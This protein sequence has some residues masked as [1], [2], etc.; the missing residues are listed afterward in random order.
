[1]PPIDFNGLD[2]TV[3]GPVRLGVLTALQTDG[4]LDFTTLKQ[5]LDVADGALGLFDLMA[6]EAA[7]VPTHRAALPLIL[8]QLPRSHAD[9][10][11]VSLQADVAR[12][13]VE[14]AR[15]GPGPGAR[16]RTVARL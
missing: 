4:A 15:A 1:M 16:S 9:S 8:V 10:F 2:S 5:R 6:A 12:A 11:K 3:H 14:I 13:R 7:T